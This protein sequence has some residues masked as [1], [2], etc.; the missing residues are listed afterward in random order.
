V[1]DLGMNSQGTHA[2]WPEFIITDE[3]VPGARFSVS[4]GTPPHAVNSIGMSFDGCGGGCIGRMY[5]SKNGTYSVINGSVDLSGDP[6]D[7]SATFVTDG[8]VAE[9]NQNSTPGSPLNH[10]EIRISQ[11]A[12]EVWAGDP[13][14]STLKKI[15]H[16]SNLGLTFSK[17][18]VWLSD[19]H[20]NAR[21]AIEPCQCGT[22]YDHT[23]LWDNLGFDG[24]KTYRDLG[25]DVLYA[26]VPGQNSIGGDPETNE[27]Y[28]VGTTARSFTL[29]NVSW[30]QTPTKVKIVYNVYAHWAVGIPVTVSASLNGHAFVTGKPTNAA[31]IDSYSIEL[32]VSDVVSGTNTLSLKSTDGATGISN[33]SLILV[34]GASV[35]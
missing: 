3:P 32:P 14:S 35:P 34:A 8:S 11:N 24:P 17:G 22:K 28:I 27:G 31:A 10:V 18:L 20:Y 13:G 2:A 30:K 7:P 33:I 5:M 23:F 9:A 6:L 12:L 4:G 25:F 1:F 15:A 26:N 16:A 29:P 19:T 21:K